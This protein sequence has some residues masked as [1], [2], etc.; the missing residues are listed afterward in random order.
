[1]RTTR[2]GAEFSPYETIPVYCAKSMDFPALL[3]S[4]IALEDVNFNES[5]LG[6]ISPP[7]PTRAE[8]PPAPAARNSEAL[9][10]P[11]HPPST[12]RARVATSEP[13]TPPS[14]P[15][16]T[17][18]DH[19]LSGSHARRAKKRAAA[20]AQ[21]GR[22]PKQRTVERYQLNAAPIMTQLDAK[23]LPATRGAYGA[24][25]SKLQ[26]GD[27]KMWTA[28]ELEKQGLQRVRWQANDSHPLV[29]RGGK[30]VAV[31]VG[32]PNDTSYVPSTLRAYDFI[33]RGASSEYF[34]KEE[35]DHRRGQYPTLHTGVTYGKG[36]SVP[37]YLKNDKH[38]G[39]LDNFL[40]NPDIQ[41]MA[42]CA[43]AAFRLWAPDVYSYY[44]DRLSLMW[45]RTGLRRNFERSI[46]PC[47]TFNIGPN[48]WTYRHRDSLNCPF[49]W[50]GVQSMGR[51]DPTKGGHL[52]L[53]EAGVFIEF[54]PGSLILIPS[55]TISHSNI[56]VQPGD[57]RA[58]FT[59]YCS[60]GI[61]RYVDNGFR[62]ESVFAEEDPAGYQKMCEM[63]ESRWET[64][65][66]LLSNWTDIK[67]QAVTKVVGA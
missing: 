65:I 32:P 28:R 51:F 40:A 15:S 52:I 56:P 9:S 16:P 27:K 20:F 24:S 1:M 66:S 8:T 19:K 3:R 37:V 11:E 6:M 49:G 21:D 46:F 4:S 39:L 61:F 44:E 63:K 41:R 59:Q 14:A 22:A 13:A 2:S 48:V 10:D 33:V 57:C 62:T 45:E 18:A 36:T 53:W 35:I 42:S 64:G 47:A 67:R 7:S 17:P 26:R 55:A 23:N 54:P 25:S 31:M 43:D 34:T 38:R 50:C 60:G 12:K 58:S 29:E 30:I 5:E